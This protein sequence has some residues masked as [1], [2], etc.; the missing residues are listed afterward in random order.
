MNIKYLTKYIYVFTIEFMCKRNHTDLVIIICICPP[1]LICFWRFTFCIQTG[2]P[3]LWPWVCCKRKT[4][5]HFD[6]LIVLC[7]VCRWPGLGR[8]GVPRHL[9]PAAVERDLFVNV[10]PSTRWQWERFRSRAFADSCT[11]WGYLWGG[12]STYTA[13]T[14]LHSY[15]QWVGWT[16]AQRTT[17]LVAANSV[18]R[19]LCVRLL[20]KNQI[21]QH[22]IK[23]IYNASISLNRVY[24][25]SG[26]RG[27]LGG[28]GM[29]VHRKYRQWQEWT[30]YEILK[31]SAVN[32]ETKAR[33]CSYDFWDMN[34]IWSTTYSWNI[35]RNNFVIVLRDYD[36]FVF[37]QFLI[38]F[39]MFFF[40]YWILLLDLKS[41]LL[42]NSILQ[43][44]DNYENW[45]WF[46]KSRINP[47]V[48][49]CNNYGSG[50]ITLHQAGES[51]SFIH[52]YLSMYQNV[53]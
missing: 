41:I 1:R 23:L 13:H 21:M 5:N 24:C 43:H 16:R 52:Y 48:A 49:T 44:F 33:D 50:Y 37:N 46:I 10:C 15:P 25:E 4:K 26:R 18:L 32:V 29:Y 19:D 22:T 39:Q 28:Y 11:D 14:Q 8:V 36:A 53:Q 3:D 30:V 9:S 6:A 38:E 47:M 17:S 51:L 45:N 27:G 42:S 12:S 40:S 20:G 7:T 35:G 2:W 34:E 31:Q